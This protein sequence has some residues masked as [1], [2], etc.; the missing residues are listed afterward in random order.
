MTQSFEPYSAAVWILSSDRNKINWHD[1]DDV[2]RFLDI[3]GDFLPYKRFTLGDEE[4]YGEG[5]W[6][7]P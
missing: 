6:D 3:P 5:L 4:I 7:I 2:D 1:S